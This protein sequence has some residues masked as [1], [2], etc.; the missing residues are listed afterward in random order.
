[1]TCREASIGQSCAEFNLLSHVAAS[2]YCKYGAKGSY[3]KFL[4]RI[5]RSR[6]LFR[7]SEDTKLEKGQRALEAAES[8]VTSEFLNSSS[9]GKCRI[10]D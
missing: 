1:M 6:K 5:E 2:T 7:I 4:S 9:G 10:L 3:R 8:R